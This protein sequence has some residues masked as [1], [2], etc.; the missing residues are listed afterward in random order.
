ESGAAVVR[1]RALRRQVR[2][3]AVGAASGQQSRRQKAGD[4]RLSESIHS[5][6]L[7][8]RNGPPSRVRQLGQARQVPGLQFSGGPSGTGVGSWL[9]T[10]AGGTG[11]GR[12]RGP[13]N[14]VVLKRR[15]TRLVERVVLTRAHDHGRA[16]QGQGRNQRQPPHG[17]IVVQGQRKG[18]RSLAGWGASF[19]QRSCGAY[20]VCVQSAVPMAC[21]QWVVGSGPAGLVLPSTPQQRWYDWQFCLAAAP[22][23][24]VVL[25]ISAVA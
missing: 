24:K 23:M 19:G 17:L 21:G 22:P 3:F 4:Q 14:R 7:L 11:T 25:H 9:P 10:R 1:E 20:W 6:S 5:D 13:V 15:P 2:S 8:G 18:A 12:S 16:N